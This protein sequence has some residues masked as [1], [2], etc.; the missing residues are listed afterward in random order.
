MSCPGTHIDRIT[1]NANRTLGFIRIERDCLQHFG[2]DST[3]VCPPPLM[4]P[5]FKKEYT[6][7]Q[8]E[9]KQ[10]NTSDFNTRSSVTAMREKLGWRSLQ[11]NRE[12]LTHVSACSTASSMELWQYL[13]LN[14]SS[15]T[16]V[17]LNAFRRPHL[18]RLLQI[19]LLSP[20]NCPVE[21]SPR[22]GSVLA[23]PG[24]VQGR[25]W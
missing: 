6:I 22:V 13:C 18:S 20:G 4:G 11:P 10:R 3:G 23:N 7:L 9:K 8:I 1:G 25:S 5:L 24:C 14:I 2:T 17:C 12:E 16:P 19:F 15:P 21:C